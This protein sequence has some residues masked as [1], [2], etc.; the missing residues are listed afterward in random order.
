MI[1]SDEEL[2]DALEQVSAWMEN[3]PRAGSPEEECFNTLLGAIENY[4][5]TLEAQADE[6]S[7][8]PERAELRRRA[9][10]LSRHWEENRT[11]LMGV[12]DGAVRASYGRRP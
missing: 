2:E 7:E 5:P 8:P 4:R 1:R 11:T 3:P 9:E 12:V 10:E 6:P